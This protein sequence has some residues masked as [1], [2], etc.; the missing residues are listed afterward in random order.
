MI[1]TLEHNDIKVPED[2]SIITIG[3]YSNCQLNKLKLTVIDNQLS[4]MC[5]LGLKKLKDMIKNDKRPEGDVTLL[6]PEIIENDSVI[7]LNH[8]IS[9]KV[10]G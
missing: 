6:T 3:N 7:K 9:K 4:K 1:S 8:D 10:K 2:L 5:D